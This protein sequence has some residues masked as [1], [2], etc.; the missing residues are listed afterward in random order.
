M[1]TIPRPLT[2]NRK[3]EQGIYRG[4]K[5][6]KVKEVWEKKM[7]KK[8]KEAVASREQR[9]KIRQKYLE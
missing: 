9:K 8:H 5:K 7:R 4:I 2:F 3:K 6:E 1:M